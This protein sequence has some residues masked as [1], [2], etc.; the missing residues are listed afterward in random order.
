M[1][2]LT[3]QSQPILAIEEAAPPSLLTDLYQLTKPRI[4]VMV[5]ITAYIGYALGVKATGTG[6]WLTLIAT[7]LG[8]AISCMGA[9]VFNQVMEIDTDALMHRTQGRPL[10]TGRMNV[11]TA[12]A[13]GTAICLTGVLILA[14]FS[15]PMGA[16]VSLLTILSYA[17]V[18]TPLKRRTSLS[19][20]IGAVPGALPPL[21]GYAAV[22]GTI[23]PEPM[24]VFA[25][26]FMWQLPHFLAIAWLHRDDYAR[27]GFPMLPVID[28]SG[29]STFR[30]I[31]IGCMALLPV[32]LMPT[33]IGFS[34]NVY[35]ITA[36]VSGIVFLALGV[37]LV[38][39]RTRA[40]ARAL[41]IAS[42]VY[43]PVVLLAMVLDSV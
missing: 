34:G 12:T 17:F 4:T 43:L 3:Q 16:L 13:L 21:I 9:S 26:M 8:T 7:L 19:T 5:V 36:L 40:H 14:L 33:V 39:G 18:Y 15:H 6:H 38:I 10:P 35:F 25:I 28:P 23:A 11:W 2:Q 29:A 41:F 32:A 27:G 1:T 42:L 22:T 31:L 37:A 30:Q 24:V 20:I